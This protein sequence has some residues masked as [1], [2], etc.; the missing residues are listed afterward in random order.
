MISALT[1]LGEGV[2]PGQGCAIEF[3]VTFVLVSTVFATTDS[4][5]SDLKGSGPLAIGLSVAM[6]HLGFVSNLFYL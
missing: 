2:T 1:T 4:S 5:R 3:L 6:C